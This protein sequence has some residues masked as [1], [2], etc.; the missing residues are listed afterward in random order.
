MRERIYSNYE[1]ISKGKLNFFFKPFFFFSE[2]RT[3]PR[4]ELNP[5][6][7][8]NFLIKKKL[9]YLFFLSLRQVSLCSP[10]CPPT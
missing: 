9:I 6:L 1:E 3:E 5:Q 8:S 2:L 10:G 7:P 4:A